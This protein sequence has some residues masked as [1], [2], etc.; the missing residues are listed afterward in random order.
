[1]SRP[2]AATRL[3]SPIFLRKQSPGKGIGLAGIMYSICCR[4]LH[5]DP[6]SLQPVTRSEF[7]KCRIR[8]FSSDARKICRKVKIFS[9]LSRVGRSDFSRGARCA[10]YSAPKPKR[11]KKTEEASASSVDEN[12]TVAEPQLALRLLSSLAAARAAPEP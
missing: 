4:V 1:M 8:L 12:S 2:P 10:K 11:P 7:A 9:G 6:R 3:I 5:G